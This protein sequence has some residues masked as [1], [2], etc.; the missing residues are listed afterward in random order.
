MNAKG[1]KKIAEAKE[2]LSVCLEN[3]MPMAQRIT[4]SSCLCGEEC[5]DF[6]NKIINVAKQVRATPVTYGQ[7]GKGDQAIVH[8]HYF[9][10]AGEAW[11]TERDKGEGEGQDGLG[12]QHQAFGKI[13]MHGNEAEYCYISIDVL[14]RHGFELD[15]YWTPK[16]I[17]ELS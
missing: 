6:A 11:I 17:A 5:L 4:L 14:L 3:F 7:E 8:L 1:N 13:S 10:A 15:L 16:T 12:V 9:G 2:L